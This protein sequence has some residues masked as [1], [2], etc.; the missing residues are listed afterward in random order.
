MNWTHA[1]TTCGFGEGESNDVSIAQEY[2]RV[3]ESSNKVPEF[4]D[5]TIYCKTAMQG[6]VRLS[7]ISSSEFLLA[8]LRNAK[9]GRGKS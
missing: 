7:A 2:F 8:S 1:A 5:Q 6:F 3:E 9:G 4:A